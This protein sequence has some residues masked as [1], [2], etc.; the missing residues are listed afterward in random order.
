[1]FSPPKAPPQDNSGA[2][3]PGEKDGAGGAGAPRAPAISPPRGGAAIRGIGEKFAANTVTGT[4]A[5]TVPLNTSPGR[6]GFGPELSLSYDSG[7]GNG[8]FGF[9]W[10]LS[11]PAVTRKTDKGLPQYADAEESDVFILSDAEDLVPVLAE[12]GG[13]WKRETLP[14][15]VLGQDEHRV[16]RY[17]PRTEGLFARVE[18]WTNLRTSATH[19]RSTTRDNV[20][21]FYGLDDNSKI[22]APP[23]FAGEP[24]RVFSWLIC[25]SFDAHG[26]AVVYE[27]A[28]ED[29]ENVALSQ[30]S[31]GAR[32][33]AANRYLKRVKYGNR[34]SRLVE[35]DLAQQGW[36]F[37]VV[38]DYDEGHYQEL[39]ADAALPPD[40]Q[41]EFARASIDPARSWAARPD[42]FSSY[43]AGF[44]VRT[45][46]RCR[47]VLM[48]HRFDELGDEPCLVR[49]TEFDYADLDYTQPRAVE[50]EL[51]HQGSTRFA[52]FV[53]SVTQSGFVRDA[54]RPVVVADGVGYVTYLKRSLPP[55]EFE[56]SKATIQ[57]DVRELDADSLENLPAGLDG[58]T[59]QWVD[60]DGEGVSG[61]LVEQAGEW[62]YKPNLGG[63]RF[64][65]LR[66]VAPRPSLADLGGGGQQLLD[67]AGDGQLDLVDF[68][69][70]S[71]GFYERTHDRTWEPFRPFA[72][73]PNVNW[74]D[75]NLRLVDLN[76]DG[77][78]DILITADEVI[79]WHP[80]LGEEGFGAAHRV[81]MPPGEGRGP[82]LVLADAGQA[83]YFADMCGDGLSALV[84]VRNGEVC[85]WPSLGHGRFGAKV[86]MD[87]APRFDAPDQFSQR[88]VRLAD[89]DGSGATDIIYLGR[90]GARIY[91]NQ[92]GNRWSA[93]RRLAQFPAL[94]SLSSVLP[95]DLLGNGTSCLVWSSPAPADARRPLRYIDLTGGRKPHLLVAAVNNLGAETRVEYAPSTRFYLEDEAAGNPW[96]TRLPFPVHVVERI[97]THDRLS[98]NRFVTRYAYHHGYFDGVEREFRG[99]GLVEQWD[100][101]EFA[102]LAGGGGLAAGMNL[103]E[104]SHVPPVL[105][106]TWFHTGLHLGRAHVSDF[107]AGL[108]AA[109]H[110]GEYYREPGLTDA[111][112]AALLLEDTA[113]PAGLSPE[114]ER[115]ACRALRG[116]M[117]RREVYA[118]DGTPEEPH[119]YTVTEQTFTVRLEQPR[120]GNRHAVFYTH[121]REVL[122]YHYERNPADPRVTHSL[123][124]EVDGFGNVVK[125]ATVGYGRRPVVNVLDGQGQVSQTP[126]PGLGELSPADRARQTA[127]LITYT[128]SEFTDPVLGDND[129]RTPMPAEARTYELT[130]LSLPAGRVRL[131]PAEVLDAGADFLGV[132]YEVTPPPN[133]QRKRL[134]E[135]VRTLYRRDDL[136][137]PL[138]LRQLQA[139]A[140]PF[141]IYRLALTQGLVSG[142]YGGRVTDAMLE[143]EARYVHSEGDSDW[144]IP[145][146][147]VF[148]SPDPAHT[149]AE[150]RAHAREHFFLPRRYRDPFH[151]AAVGTETLVTFDNYDLL[152]LETRDPL[153]NRVTAGERDA[154]GAVTAQGN[155]YRV[156]RPRL[157]TD[158]NRNRTEVAFD[159]LG[160]V[161]ARALMG[162]PE[163]GPSRG[164]RL[165]ATFRADLTRAEVAQFFADPKG[166]AA[167]PLLGEATTRIVYDPAAYWREPDPQRK[168]PAFSAALT[169]ETHASDPVPAGGLRIQVSLSYSDGFGREIQKKIQAEPGPAPARDP[170]T[171]KV[172]AGANGQ[173]QMTAGDVAP[174]W[175]GSGWTVFNNKGRPVRQYEPFFTDTHG[176][177]FDAR[178][179]VSPV[180]YYDPAGRVVATLHP[181]HTWEKVVFDAW[182]QATW[183]VGDTLLAADPA[184]D[185]DA[186]DFFRRLPDAEYLPTWHARRVGGALGPS[187]EAAARNAAVHAGTPTV[188]HL[189][190]LGRAFLT[191]A[192]NRYK[193]SDTPPADPPAEEFYGSRVISDIEGN[194]RELGDALGRAVVRYDYDMLGSPISQASMEAG[195]RR[196][197][198]DVAGKPLYAWDGRGHRVRT[199]YDAL[200]R[201][202]G[203]HLR[204]GASPELLVGRTVYGE[205]RPDPEAANLRAK[206]VEVFDQA[207][208]VTTDEY[209]FKGNPLGSRRRLASEY[210]ATLNWSAAVPLEA[211]DYLSR[212]SYDALNRPAEL[213]APDGSRVRPAF[214]EAN[215]LERVEVNVRGA[216]D[217][218]PFV[219]DIDYDAKGRRTLVAYG[220]GARTAREYD[221][222]TSRLTRLVTTRDAAAFPDDCPQPPP[223]GWPGCQAQNLQ[224]TYDA[225]GNVT[226]IHDD[227]QQAV[228]F[229]NR[230]VEPSAEYV[231]D[232]VNRLIEATGREHLGQ[233]NGQPG[234]PAPPDA[235]DASRARLEHRGDGNAVGTYFEQYAYDA[236]GNVLSV[237]HRGGDPSHPGWTR[238]YEYDEPSQLEAGKVNNRLSRTTVGGA[239]EVYAYEGPA[240][241]HGNITRMPHLP[242]MLWD[243]A[244]QLRATSRQVVNEG[245]PETTWYVYDS[246]GQRVRKVTER[247]AAAGQTPAR[248]K[249]RVYVGGF[250][251]YREFGAGGDAVTL[252]RETLHV[253][254]DKRR[255]ALVE[256]R[257]QGDDPA[258]ARLT[259]YQFDNHLGSASLELDEQ[260]RVVSYEEYFP[261]GGTS[262]QAVRG[263]TE[264]PKRYRYT[265]R[266]RDEETGLYYHVRRYYAPWLGRWTAPDPAGV[267]DGLNLYAYVHLNP[268]AAVDPGGE[269]AV[270]TVDQKKHIITY[271]T[272]VHLYADPADK[273][274]AQKAAAAGE[275]FFREQSKGQNATYTDDK[276]QV[277]AVRFDVKY[278]VHTDHAMPVTLKTDLVDNG[279]GLKVRK[280][281]RLIT[282]MDNFR[283][284]KVKAGD[285]L[286]ELK[287]K[288]RSP[289]LGGEVAAEFDITEQGHRAVGNST[290][291]IFKKRDVLTSSGGKLSLQPVDF[292]DTEL[293]DNLIH[294]TG[295]MLGFGERY[296]QSDSSFHPGFETDFMSNTK[297]FD[298]EI[299]KLHFEDAAKFALAVSHGESSS[300]VFKGYLDETNSGELLNT[301]PN[302]SAVQAE[303]RSAEAEYG[304]RFL[305]LDPY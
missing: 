85:Y 38:F 264:T 245:T 163:E 6:S 301:S 66:A 25:R 128:E 36:L 47:R 241:L 281:T 56:Y 225:A 144:W 87:D 230:R 218:T 172:L 117:L 82:R 98:G 260:A 174:R 54:T 231:Y 55:L 168:P 42:P 259:R 35:P 142:V 77:H 53:R 45:H 43:R 292:S 278:A 178:V 129:Y 34:L 234:S 290:G 165:G 229:R 200:R 69:G 106:R 243:Y 19:W 237:R 61:I 99:F 132:N 126:N 20:T 244:D 263:Q 39:A 140:L 302:Y 297:R 291:A 254:D 294:E 303:R 286:M 299:M 211:G 196:T 289:G 247:Q 150:E 216:E 32:S 198:P 70:P 194:R 284:D 282:D 300:M 12:A 24:P 48:F 227:A 28:E 153:G 63:G 26:N 88:R 5:L 275:K 288:G 29:G 285:N 80:S 215:L 184:A 274:K 134:I 131:T 107:F 295:H 30:T 123:T 246:A 269:D 149:P 57:D 192:H 8:P 170:A 277:W 83:V 58:A 193:R 280:D 189:D 62:F 257:T 81:P 258:P 183:D 137:G 154:A 2:K 287:E 114:E 118:L 185:P 119:P 133:T 72:R 217:A 41:H 201:T 180:L 79:T 270:M 159:A 15:R 256:T 267:R 209:D 160:L 147:R 162:K 164:D 171:G 232:A 252:E 226:H 23:A 86:T 102:A 214:N 11:L 84:R 293:R 298:K 279:A 251:V 22:F 130:G 148:Y 74:H 60:L 166:P 141:E 3:G 273:D 188:A 235:S 155:D 239:V 195:E 156:L 179:G 250:E 228:F 255:V 135:H 51:A 213:T 207:G 221:P 125:E 122:N 203:T 253:M 271:S 110:A 240:G 92:S 249:E 139:L 158:A 37:E 121:A 242:L 89:V 265:G 59:Y 219:T 238:A 90:D 175:V 261:Y 103:E 21:T 73:L 223:A 138:P 14:T 105:T 276:K 206:V 71:P 272:T 152:T 304:R 182:R 78:A 208:V 210:K 222:L 10:S 44:E 120:G 100:T 181:D 68:A 46:R 197:L 1:M 113:L 283:K 104:S 187:E 94:D 236:V 112:A 199:S 91:F 305:L 50:E 191:V 108:P 115:E 296:K 136:T 176:F 262:Y 202:V 109:K 161:V 190:A 268:L 4:G 177:E 27:Y 124:F 13:Q 169:R 248:M 220:N 31:E 64:G 151:T 266:E 157:V 127:A 186:G 65:A 205:V 9:G 95:A 96:V 111:Q 167:A 212:T 143:D 116:S 18:R 233:A 145:S 204:E 97:E 173:P 17:R 146:G 93:P 16:E 7:S 49:S 33:R 75:P 76:G 40:A 101:E 224:Y 67:L 52:S